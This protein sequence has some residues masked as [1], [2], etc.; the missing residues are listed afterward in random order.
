M[1]SPC[2]L[3]RHC[4]FFSTTY[5]HLRQKKGLHISCGV[6]EGFQRWIGSRNWCPA[7]SPPVSI[8]KG[9]PHSMNSRESWKCH[10]DVLNF[11]LTGVIEL[12]G[13]ETIFLWYIWSISPKVP[14]HSL[15]WCHFFG[16]QLIWLAISHGFTGW[17]STIQTV[18][19]FFFNDPITHSIHVCGTYLPT[20]TVEINH[21]C[22]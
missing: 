20:C 11:D 18:V 19:M 13:D 10:S 5:I 2:C 9:K 4:P 3:F 1:F 15:G 8:P 16:S 14:R 6:W 7:E 22:R 17:M 21:S 12:W